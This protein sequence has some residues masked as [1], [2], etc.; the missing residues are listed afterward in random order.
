MNNPQQ[1]FGIKY[2]PYWA[3]ITEASPILEGNGQVI[4]HYED[5]AEASAAHFESASSSQNYDPDFLQH[6]ATEIYID[7]ATTT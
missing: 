4:V 3:K 7:L 1:K 2:D 6:K 5:I